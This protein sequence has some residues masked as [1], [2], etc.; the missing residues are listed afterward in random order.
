MAS[1]NPR[2]VI[3]SDAPSALVLVVEANAAAIVPLGTAPV[4][5]VPGFEWSLS[6][7]ASVV[8]VGIAC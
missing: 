3:A 2:G 4:H 8:K 5:S 6:G 1:Q 7:Y